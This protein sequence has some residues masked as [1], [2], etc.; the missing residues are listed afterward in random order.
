MLRFTAARLALIPPMLLGSRSSSSRCCG[1]DRATRRSIICACRRSRRPTPPSPM[2][3]RCSAST[4]PS[5]SSTSTGCGGRCRAISASPTPRAAGAAGASG[6]LPATLELAGTALVV[7][8]GL[9]L[10]LGAGRPGIAADGRTGWSAASRCSAS[11]CRISGS[12]SCSS[13]AFSVSLGWLPAMGSGTALHL[14][15]PALAIGLMSLSVNARLLRASMLEVAGTRH[16][17]YARLRGLPERAVT[18]RHVFRNA[19]VP[20]VVTAT[21]MHV[22][23]LLAGA[24]V[25]ET[26]FSWPGIGRYAVSAIYDRDYPV[27]QCF[28]LVMTVVFVLC[29]LA[30]DL[31]YA[32][33]DPRIPPRGRDRMSTAGLMSAR[34]GP[35]A[36]AGGLAAGFVL[37][38]LLGPLAAPHD[39][40]R[41]ISPPTVRGARPHASPRHRPSRPRHPLA[42]DRRGPHHPRLGPRRA[43]ARRGF[44]PRGRGA[45][46]DGGR[47]GRC[48]ADAPVRRL[49]HRADLRPGPVHDRRAGHRPRQRRG[50]H[51]AVALGLVRADRARPRPR[52]EDPRL[53]AGGADRAGAPPL[54]IF[55]EHV[56]PGLVPPLAALATLDIGH[57]ALHVAGLSFL[58]LGVQPP[59]PEWGVMIND[60]RPFFWTRPFLVVWPG[61]RSRSRSSPSTA[62]ATPCA[63][64]S[65]RRSRRGAACER[66]DP[67]DR[68]APRRDPASGRAGAF[69][70]GRHPVP[71]YRPGAGPRR[72]QRVRQVARLRRPPR[73]AAAGHPEGG[74]R[75]SSSTGRRR[76][77]CP[78]PCVAG[79]SP[80]CSRP[81]APPST[82][83]GRS[84][85]MPARPW[86][87]RGSAAGP[88]GRRCGRPWRR[89]G[90]GTMRACRIST[91]V[92]DVRAACCSGR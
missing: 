32:W 3:A 22:G 81:R 39:P 53:R 5:S 33:L 26:I 28:T 69:G 12:P 48:G 54:A 77:R 19:L 14:V 57:M 74:R 7:S 72:R 58:G 36:V 52:P 71:A 15:M 43:R 91:H 82:P 90:S 20:V 66:A 40:W 84:A 59:T 83:C 63:T 17:L 21:G 18:R 35:V 25:V 13:R 49:P 34:P 27:I 29:N 2:H 75:A 8:L 88:A 56:L 67:A 80:P 51:R 79:R 31:A 73:R 1:W 37:L 61:W 85:T 38:A 62:S 16:V 41:S 70:A 46:R 10:P 9:S 50:G 11:R 47:A 68:G 65:T 45:R 87:W 4:G 92:P 89:S 55:T 86:R 44:R 60:A 42:P 76:R 30:V 23:E 78:P 24:L 6:Y 64:A